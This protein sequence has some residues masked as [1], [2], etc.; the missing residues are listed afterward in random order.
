MPSFGAIK[1][2]QTRCPGAPR[3][4]CKKALEDNDDDVD[5]AAAFIS[6]TTEFKDVKAPPTKMSGG[7]GNLSLADHE[8]G[9]ACIEIIEENTTVSV[10]RIEEGDRETFPSYGD[11]LRVHYKGFLA[12]DGTQFDSSY[13]RG[14]PFDFKFGKGEVI[15]GWDEALKQ[16][17]LGEKALVM[18]P[19]AKG[20]GEQGSGTGAVPPGADLKF[21]IELLEIRQ[22]TSCL[23][24]GRHGGV[25]KDSHEYQQ[26]A[27]QLL[28][29]G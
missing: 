16:M 20:Y 23:G 5:K 22:Q 21:E 6:D 15:K 1:V 28:G 3:P 11:T 27:N 26:L 10:L 18:I 17:S 24:A 25:Q 7:G 12:E 19:A 14:K 9:R 29:R 13:E 4:L 2:V 8:A